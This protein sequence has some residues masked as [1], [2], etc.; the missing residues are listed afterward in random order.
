[1]KS[2]HPYLLALLAVLLP[3]HSNAASVDLPIVDN[4]AAYDAQGDLIFDSI[5]SDHRLRVHWLN[6][7][8]LN[9][10]WAYRGILEIDISALPS[11]ANISS[12]TLNIDPTLLSSSEGNPGFDFLGYVGNGVLDL[13][14]ADAGDQLID[15]LVLDGSAFQVDFTAFLQTLLAAG[16]TFLGVNI[17]SDD[18]GKTFNTFDEEFRAPSYTTTSTVLPGPSFTVN[19]GTA[20]APSSALLL[21]AGLLFRWFRNR[22]A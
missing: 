18:E 13:A 17:R 10:R 2:I 15:N 19:Y 1:M 4:I 20:A 9:Q 7:N 8:Y 21:I 3:A 6:V 16:D 12:A 5:S 22:R 14:D 11:D